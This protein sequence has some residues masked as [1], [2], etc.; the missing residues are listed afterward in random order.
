LTE[1][2]LGLACGAFAG[3][4]ERA[5]DEGDGKTDK[6]SA[7]AIIEVCVMGAE[8]FVEE[9]HREAAS[10]TEVA[11]GKDSAGF[12]CEISSCEAHDGFS[13]RVLVSETEPGE[14]GHLDGN[15]S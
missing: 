12:G 3:E 9:R 4:A 14:E 7:K 13:F 10:E 15:E 2:G 8:L 1:Q 6:K 11:D 5:E